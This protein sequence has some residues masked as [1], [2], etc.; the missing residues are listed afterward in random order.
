M[1]AQTTQMYETKIAE[2]IKQIED[3]HSFAEQAAEKLDMMQKLLNDHQNSI[4]V[5]HL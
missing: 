1:L 4:K 3:K 2:L 5:G